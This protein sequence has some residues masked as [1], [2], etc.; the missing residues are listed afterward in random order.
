MLNFFI[1]LSSMNGQMHADTDYIYLHRKV[2]PPYY[3]SQQFVL[4]LKSYKG[5]GSR[6]NNMNNKNL[7]LLHLTISALVLVKIHFDRQ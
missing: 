1:I 3:G 2:L 5:F 4:S 7:K 6:Y